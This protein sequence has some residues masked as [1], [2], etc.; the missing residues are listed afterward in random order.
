MVFTGAINRALTGPADY[1]FSL[2]EVSLCPDIVANIICIG[3]HYSEW[4]T[5][6][7]VSSTLQVSTL[8]PLERQI[9][10]IKIF[11]TFYRNYSH[12]YLSECNVS[13]KLPSKGEAFSP[14]SICSEETWSFNSS[15]SFKSL[16]NISVK[17]THWLK[18]RIK[19]S[20]TNIT[21][22]QFQ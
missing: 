16:E 15:L 11:Y 9:E 22:V 6:I 2:L 21:E 13:Y 18:I 1:L 14:I 19:F 3:K 12:S 8:K 20:L 4:N 7:S 10:N 5:S 17:M